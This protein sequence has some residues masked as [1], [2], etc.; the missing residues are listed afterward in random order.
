MLTRLL[1]PR[2]TG[3]SL[4]AMDNSH[5][6]LVAL[7]MRQDGFEH[8]RCGT[9]LSNRF[10]IALPAGYRRRMR[11]LGR[12]AV[13]ACLREHNASAAGGTALSG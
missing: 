2:S 10:R 3:I 11:K 1:S 12:C 7:L 8:Y 6:A 9:S 5:V 4:Q 13:A